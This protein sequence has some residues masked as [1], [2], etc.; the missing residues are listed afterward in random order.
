[1]LVPGEIAEGALAV[2]AP[3]GHLQQS[4]LRLER[5]AVD[6]GVV[7]KQVEYLLSRHESSPFPVWIYYSRKMFT[8]QGDI[9]VD[10]AWEKV[11]Y[12]LS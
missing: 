4:A 9:L 1:M 7:V 2:A 6:L 11:V 5:R 12:C 3:V 8:K 10:T